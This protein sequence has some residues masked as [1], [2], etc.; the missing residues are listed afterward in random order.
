MDTARRDR[1][2]AGARAI[3]VEHHAHAKERGAK[4]D[5]EQVRVLRRVFRQT[6]IDEQ[7]HANTADDDRRQHH[8]EDGEILQAK[9]VL[10]DV[11]TRHAAAME[12][13]AK[14]EADEDSEAEAGGTKQTRH[15]HSPITL[16]GRGT[17]RPKPEG[18]SRT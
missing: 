11:A 7:H 17:L 12:Q 1:R 8:L 14:P 5:A 9:L 15:W 2:E 3:A 10:D 4:R 16:F 18:R 6:A 13:E